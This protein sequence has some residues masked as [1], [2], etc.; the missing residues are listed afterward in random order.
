[1]LLHSIST[2]TQKTTPLQ[3]MQTKVPRSSNEVAEGAWACPQCTYLNGADIETCEMCSCK[4]G[5]TTATQGI[6]VD[7]F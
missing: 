3:S 2:I 7:I 4:K 5:A 6:D 1:M